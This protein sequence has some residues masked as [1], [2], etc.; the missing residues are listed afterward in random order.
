M[1]VSVRVRSLLPGKTEPTKPVVRETDV[2]SLLRGITPL[3]LSVREAARVHSHLR[4]ETEKLP[5]NLVLTR[6]SIER[7]EEDFVET[8]NKFW[9][10]LISV[11][12]L[13]RDLGKG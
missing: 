6:C 9:G 13:A 4:G 2:R 5:E 8:G 11:L 1:D 10:W 3:G 12:A 7:R